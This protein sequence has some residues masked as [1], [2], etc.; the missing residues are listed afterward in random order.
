M[1]KEVFPF[2][3]IPEDLDVSDEQIEKISENRG[4]HEMEGRVVEIKRKS[5]DLIVITGIVDEMRMMDI[6]K[7]K[8]G[9]L[10][11]A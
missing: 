8:P 10:R 11:L 6:I 7:G 3:E 2:G 4:E 5:F 9:K 1:L